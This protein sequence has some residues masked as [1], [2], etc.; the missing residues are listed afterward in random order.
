MYL[1]CVKKVNEF[2]ITLKN[3]EVLRQVLQKTRYNVNVII[4]SGK[5]ALKD[6]YY[7]KCIIDKIDNILN[8]NVISKHDIHGCVR[9]KRKDLMEHFKSQLE[10]GK[11]EFVMKRRR[12]V[13]ALEEKKEEIDVEKEGNGKDKGKGRNVNKR[14]K[15]FMHN[16]KIVD[17]V[18]MK[19]PMSIIV[20]INI[21]IYIYICKC[22][23]E[24]KSYDEDVEV[25]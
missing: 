9:K 12:I 2:I 7:D 24:I 3:F 19:G 14:D 13:K 10:F 20:S 6:F 18:T 21:C 15:Y 11:N 17:G 23:L 22:F 1:H 16:I 25:L 5:G 8:K 4:Q